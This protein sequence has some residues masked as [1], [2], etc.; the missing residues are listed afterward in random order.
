MDFLYSI[1][2]AIILYAPVL[3]VYITQI[4][5]WI[6]TFRKFRALDVSN[7]VKPV[8]AKVNT[9]CDE[10]QALN[11]KVEEFANEKADL[12]T[13]INDLKATLSEKDA[14]IAE[15]KEFLKNLSTENVELKAQLRR[16]SECVAK[17]PLNA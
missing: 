9:T 15:I 6:V 7:Q 17:E 1:E 14:E 3:L 10:I 16:K 2:E 5:D 13:A 8:L 12:K 4:V 11:A